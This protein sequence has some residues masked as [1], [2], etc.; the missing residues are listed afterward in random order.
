[1]PGF[2]AVIFDMDGTLIAS[3]LD[4]AAIRAEF[5][6]APGD[7]IIEQLDARPPAERDRCRQRLAEIEM[8]AA[9]EATLIPGAVE[10]VEAVR[11][12]GLKTA[13]LTRNARPVMETL[14]GRFGAL[15]FDLC[16]SREDGPIKPEPDG[17]L[18]ACRQLNVAPE[19][20][21]C[22]G[23][24]HYDI[25]AANAAGTTS[26]LL[27]QGPRPE[28]ADQADRV[29]TALAELPGVLGI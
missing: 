22:V 1:M 13:L 9:A 24:Y 29:I 8:T 25:T 19:R 21:A 26:I 6:V 15:R 16:W 27:A 7:G 3:P 28:F 5:G 4:F 20:T 23:D 17:V 2:D 12:A 18:R 14:L 10:T 11:A